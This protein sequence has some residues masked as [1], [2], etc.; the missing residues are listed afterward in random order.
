MKNYVA[1]KL[2]GWLFVIFSVALVGNT[3]LQLIQNRGADW[4][5][6]SLGILSAILGV[7][8]IRVLLE[9][10]DVVFAIYRHLKDH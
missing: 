2:T 4:F 5:T 9:F 8:L 10:V 1:P 3:L 7:V 6:W